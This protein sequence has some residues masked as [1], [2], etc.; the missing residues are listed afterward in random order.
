MLSISRD[1]VRLQEVANSAASVMSLFA[2]GS[3][4]TNRA[5]KSETDPMR[6]SRRQVFSLAAV[7]IALDIVLTAPLV[8]PGNLHLL[9]LGDYP[10]SPHPAFAPSIYGFPP[11]I[12]SRAPIEATL[13]WL[14]QIFHWEP[15]SLIPFTATAPLACAGFSRIFP[16]KAIAIGVATLMY[17]VNPFI[18]ERMVNGQIYVVMGY[19]LLPILLA[20]VIRPFTS[21][22]ATATLGGFIFALS[23]A[24]SVHYI[25]IGGLLLLVVLLTHLALRQVRVVWAVAG[26]GLVGI[27]L[28]LYW[29]IPAFRAMRTMQSNVTDLDLSVF[30][31][32]GDPMWGIAVNVL[33]L[34]GFWRPGAPL[35]K[36]HIS[37]WPFLLLA[38]LVVAGMGVYELYSGS[39]CRGRA[40]ALS[41]VVLVVVGGVLAVGALGPTRGSFT[42]LFDH[43]PGFKVMREAEK[44]SALIAVAYATAFGA[45]AEVISRSLN[46]DIAK[47]F[48][49]VCVATL[50][51]L[52][53]YTELWGL[54]GYARPS[55]YP[56]SWSAADRA[57]SPGA[58]AL[59]LPWGAYLQVPWIGSRVVANPVS[60]YFSRPVISGDDLE[61]GPIATESSNPRS[62]FLQFCLSEGDQL[63]EFG[64]LLAPLGIRYVILTKVPGWQSFNWLDRQSD[65]SLIYD[66]PTIAI[67]ENL[68]I[69]PTAYEPTQRLLLSDWGQVVALAQRRPLIDYLVEVQHARPGPLVMP[70]MASISAPQAP[71]ILRVTRNTPVSE[72]FYLKGGPRMVVLTDPSYSGWQLTGFS[73][74]SQFGVTV[75]F[76]NS[77]NIRRS[78]LAV[79]VYGPWRFDE[80]CDIIGAFLVLADVVLLAVIFIR[81]LKPLA[82]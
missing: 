2:R 8:G 73:T 58:T 75:A 6:L 33:G 63:A 68:E 81:R 57:M 54:D 22:V 10:T 30:Q 3:K 37:G 32:Q 28:N 35:V 1:R 47:I 11:G 53:G 12:T 4:G 79:A 39:A 61:A 42:W 56:T 66:S 15:A 7:V 40:L 31:T 48:C 18:Y 34:Y 16:G 9:D 26:S 21:L 41:C 72:A 43:V 19:S 14:F 65:I 25:F 52:Y 60:G 23:I 51:L 50:P 64:R 77:T 46:R 20:L 69:V 82:S 55:V 17:T 76:K 45:G 59:A 29:L 71:T 74:T 80:A 36:N 24:L 27:L 67:Y 70:R 49:I 38:I 78:M 44:F 5:G 62:L 13:Y